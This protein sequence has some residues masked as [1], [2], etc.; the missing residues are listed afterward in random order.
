MFD[1]FQSNFDKLVK[2]K[3]FSPEVLK[4]KKLNFDNFLKNGFPNK[5]LEDWKFL[6][7]NQIL[8]SEFKNFD[9]DQAKFDTQIE[10][11]KVIKNFDHNQIFLLDGELFKNNFEF[12]DLDKIKISNREYFNEKINKNSLVNLNHAF[13]KKSIKIEVLKG[14][15]A[16]KPIVIYNYISDQA[17]SSVINSNINI[18]LGENSTLELINLSNSPK[19][20]NFLNSY[21]GINIKDNATLKAFNINEGKTNTI[22][23]NYNEIDLSKNSHLEYFIYSTGSTFAKHEIY[24][25]FNQPYGSAVINGVLNLEKDNQHEIKTVINHNDENCRSYQLIK[26]AL[27]DNSKGVYQGKIFVDQKA[28]KTDGYQLSRAL[29]L[30]EETEFNAKPELEIYADDV[31]C[32]HGSTSG[33][34][35]E[36][37]IFYLMSRG[38]SYN[39]SR[40]LLINGFLQEVIEKI[41]TP[42]IKKLIKKITG[43]R[44]EN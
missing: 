41:S 32:S 1:I 8:N 26:N 19:C 24:C 42:E 10:F 11:F 43:I 23:Y 21:C 17:K 44:D 5:K 33:N 13:T 18:E 29:L 7:L 37:A 34:I 22:E 31:K 3:N 14:Y 28:Q 40:Q 30:S 36:N 38:L 35:D 20:S 9:F 39:Q 2:E 27:N 16:K 12:D 25:S 4:I 6:D 15:R